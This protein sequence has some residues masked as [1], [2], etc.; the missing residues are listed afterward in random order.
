MIFEFSIDY[1]MGK[2]RFAMVKRILLLVVFLSIVLVTT[3]AAFASPERICSQK[4][5]CVQ[6][7]DYLKYT[8][9]VY[10]HNGTISY[11]FGNYIDPNTLKVAIT[12]L[13]TG[14]TI[15]AQSTLNLKNATL[16][17]SDGSKG[18]FFF[19]V[20]TPINPNEIAASPF[21]ATTGMYNDYQRSA[22]AIEASNGTDS[23]EVVIDK[24][25]GVLLAFKVQH[26]Q[27]ISGQPVATGTS[28]ELVDTNLITSSDLQGTN[29]SPSTTVV[30]NTTSIPNSISNPPNSNSNPQ[31]LNFNPPNSSPS[32][33]PTIIYI[34]IAIAA[35]G[36]GAG[37]MILQKRKHKSA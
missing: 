2:R 10:G 35:A 20:L 18:A 13:V 4:Q 12:T 8:A 28:F 15:N 3:H 17:N 24:E 31:N 6:P 27:L 9:D 19:M 29:E 14:Q 22:Y 36:A 34:G 26:V 16:V 33:D 5:I 11:N 21:K 25:T 37:I 1:Y 23:Q 7:G 32:S 30:N